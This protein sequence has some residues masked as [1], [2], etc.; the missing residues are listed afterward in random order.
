MENL[1][2][3]LAE[4]ENEIRSI[5]N[6]ITEREEEEIH[7]RFSEDVKPIIFSEIGNVREDVAEDLIADVRELERLLVESSG[8]SRQK[9]SVRTRGNLQFLQ[10]DEITD[11]EAR[12]DHYTTTNHPDEGIYK[13]ADIEQLIDELCEKLANRLGDWNL[14]RARTAILNTKERLLDSREDNN[15]EIEG[16]IEKKIQEVIAQI[17]EIESDR[18]VE[19][20]K[21]GN[22]LFSDLSESVKSETEV[23]RYYMEDKPAKDM[24]VLDTNCRE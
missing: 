9:E 2:S 21:G 20:S 3:K 22:N 8:N 1:N 7:G 14:T 19:E 11:L 4:L 10:T 23:E 12:A 16:R 18:N 15:F 6:E 24:Q 13:E 5:Y 17:E